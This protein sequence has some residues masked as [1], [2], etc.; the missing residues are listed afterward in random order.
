MRYI[1]TVTMEFPLSE[2]QIRAAF[3]QVSFPSEFTPPDG[4]AVFHQTN[5]PAYDPVT[6]GYREIAPAQINGEWTQQWEVYD[7]PP[8][9][10]ASNQAQAHQALMDRIAAETQ[11]R[12][13]AFASTRGYD[14]MLSLCSYAA[15]AIPKFAAEGSYGVSARDA[16]WATLYDILAEVEAGTRPI[17]AGF[18]EI[19]P[20]LPPLVWP[21]N[22]V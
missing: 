20:E 3:P 11:A 21:E 18:E 5:A 10:A 15:S 6:Q 22:A 12:L 1:N 13:D 2:Q 7:L 14:G 9:Q 4:Y 19:E 8:E 16:T 17:P